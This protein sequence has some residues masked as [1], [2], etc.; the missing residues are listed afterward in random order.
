VRR[1]GVL[2]LTVGVIA[3]FAIP[4]AGATSAANPSSYLLLLNGAPSPHLAQ[5]VSAAGGTLTRAFPQV[6][7]AVASSTDPAFRANAARLGTVVPNLGLQWV[8]PVQ[9]VAGPSVELANPPFSGSADFFFDLQWGHAAIDAVAAW[10]TGA[11]GAGARVAVL[12]TGFDL[13]HPDLAPNIDLANS[14]DMTGEG[15]Q[16][17]LPDPFSHGTHVAG[18]VAAAENDFGII[19]VAPDA[20][21]VLVK[22]LGDAGSG[23]FDDVIA[24]IVHATDVG[25]HVINMSLGASLPR[26]GI[27]EEGV[28]ARDVAE[29]VNALGRATSYAYQRGTTVISSAGNDANDG[30][31]DKDL[32]YLPA[33]APR[34]LSISATAPIGWA[35]APLTTFL[36][37]PASY[38]NVGRSTIDLAAPG[39]DFVYPGEENCTIAGLLRPCWVFDLVFSTGNDSWYWSAGT[40]MAAPHAAGVAALIVGEHDGAIA[41]AQVASILRRSADDL[42][43]PGKDPFYGHGR[44]NA[45]RAVG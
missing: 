2:F 11:R 43:S 7:I 40:S 15:L 25:S 8:E 34:V 37:E 44:V 16:Y 20:E 31:K 5:Q 29:L 22:V 36:D 26:R 19:G 39:G 42:G 18:T 41:P 21:L 27:P 10:E 1:L 6:G 14:A 28:T 23:S 33:D 35:T 17:S 13:D 30:D 4:S 24:G 38:T 3:T 32:V 45:Y 9:P 12:D